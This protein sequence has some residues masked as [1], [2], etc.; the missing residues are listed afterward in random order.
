MPADWFCFT[1]DESGPWSLKQ[2]RNMLRSGDLEP[3]DLV[4]RP[5]SPL[6]ESIESVPELRSWTS[7]GPRQGR[8]SER[9]TVPEFRHAITLAVVI[10]FIMLL[11]IGLTPLLFSH[12][13]VSSAPTRDAS[14]RSESRNALPAELP[15]ETLIPV[16]GF[17]Q[18]DWMKSAS[19]SDDL[20]QIVYVSY[21][22][23]STLDDLYIAARQSSSAP[24]TRHRRISATVTPARESQPTLSPDGLTLAYLEIEGSPRLLITQRRSTSHPFDKPRPFRFSLSKKPAPRDVAND[25][26]VNAARPA[27][28]HQ[29]QEFDRGSTGFKFGTLIDAPQFLD[30][31]TLKVAI[32]DA[33]S[34]RRR[35]LFF[36][37]RE[38]PC[39]WRLIDM[40]SSFPDQGPCF[41]IQRHVGIV[42][43]ERGLSRVRFLDKSPFLSAQAIPS[44]QNLSDDLRRF[45]EMVW[46]TPANN[47]LFFSSVRA[48]ESYRGRRTL[49]M[50]RLRDPL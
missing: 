12:A 35:W 49:W 23:E 22:N 7:S 16:P 29:L 34:R 46:Y 18:I 6:W 39:Q 27:I 15:V 36:K 5:G 50:F 47:L 25:D 8:I 2:L 40:T 13:R 41:L 32:L 28:L 17:D 43:T 4:R 14:R 44:C 11:A 48:S 20:R 45:H 21:T 3:T 26:N 31:T 42:A 19:L 37:R 10:C 33:S 30:D 24:F 38:K 1:D 9:R